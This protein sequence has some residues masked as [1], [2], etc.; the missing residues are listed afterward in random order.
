M[1]IQWTDDLAT[2]SAK[3]DTQHQAIFREDQQHARG[4]Q[5]G[6]GERAKWTELLAFLEDYVVSHFS[7][8]ER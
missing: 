3:I 2:G 4:V 1:A 7:T 8:E 6:E 5:Q